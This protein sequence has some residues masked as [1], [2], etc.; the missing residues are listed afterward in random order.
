MSDGNSR[1]LAFPMW[2][3]GFMHDGADGVATVWDET[4]TPVAQTGS[5]VMIAGGHHG[6]E[7]GPPPP[8]FKDEW[9]HVRPPMRTLPFHMLR[10]KRIQA[11]RRSALL[12]AAARCTL[13]PASVGRLRAAASCRG[14][15]YL[16]AKKQIPNNLS[17]VFVSYR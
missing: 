7:G 14:A 2:P 9:N 17:A 15:P 16:S 5:R 6:G 4:G 12:H 11:S 13:T 1:Q 10:T 3:P 8:E